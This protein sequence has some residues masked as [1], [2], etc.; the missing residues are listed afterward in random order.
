VAEDYLPL[1]LL[2]SRR[3]NIERIYPEFLIPNKTRDL[4]LESSRKERQENPQKISIIW[5][6]IVGNLE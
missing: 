6:R 3:K 2:D 4:S 5:N 1:R